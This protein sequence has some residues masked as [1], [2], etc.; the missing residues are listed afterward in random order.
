MNPRS[1]NELSHE[2]IGAAI[3]VHRELGPGLLESAY[4]AAY[5]HELTL[6]AIPHVRQR[7][8][9]VV[10]K[11]AVVDVAYR[12]DI[13]VEERLAIELK[14]VEKILPLYSTQLL[15]YLRLGRFP[16]GLLINFNV[17]RLIDG[18]ERVSNNAPN[19]SAPSASSAFQL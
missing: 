13:L 11:G 8:M 3:E 5:S 14:A 2:L 7:E 1:I 10:Y 18:V 9:P 15:T 6:R 4:E 19:L 12:I 16:L 17:G